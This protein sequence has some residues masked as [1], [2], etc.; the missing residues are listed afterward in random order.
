MS[1]KLNI[2]IIHNNCSGETSILQGICDQITANFN[3]SVSCLKITNTI[4]PR[5]LR[6]TISRLYKIHFH[7][8]FLVDHFIKSITVSGSFNN[9]DIIICTTGA[10][11]FIARL[12]QRAHHKTY[13]ICWRKPSGYSHSSQLFDLIVRYSEDEKP[14]PKGNTQ[15]FATKPIY[16]VKINKKSIE[17]LGTRFLKQKKLDADS[18]RWALILGG[19]SQRCPFTNNDIRELTPSLRKLSER[20]GIRWLITTSRRSPKNWASILQDEIGEHIDYLVDFHKSPEHVMAPYL[21]ACQTVCVTE[22]TA[23]M[24]SECL[25]SGKPTVILTM[26]PSQKGQK[27]DTYHVNMIEHLIKSNLVPSCQFKD[28]SSIKVSA[29][30][31]KIYENKMKE[32]ESVL[33]NGI[34]N[35]KFKSHE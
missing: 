9:P 5:W 22:D 3:T 27:Y 18:T 2:T 19:I 13:T 1:Q 28:L 35:F 31:S 6:K 25:A 34:S 20:H 29:T 24:L 23:T 8:R 7:P 33:L 12:Y 17:G 11:S 32:L 15:L 4:E 21:D 14:R 30:H 10:P 16:P 26:P